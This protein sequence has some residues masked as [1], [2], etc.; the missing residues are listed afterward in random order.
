[1]FLS[2]TL[3]RNGPG[4]AREILDMNKHLFHFIMAIL[5]GVMISL[6]VD[7]VIGFSYPAK[8]WVTFI[9]EMTNFIWGAIVGGIIAR[10]IDK[11]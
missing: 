6:L 4:D 3:T 1:M 2:R 5:F 7:A 8:N 11:S 9:H 10:G